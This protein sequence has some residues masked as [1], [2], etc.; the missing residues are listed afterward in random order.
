MGI[1]LQGSRKKAVLMTKVCTH[2]RDKNVAMRMLEKSLRR[3]R[4]DYL[5]ICQIHEVVYWSDPDL[6]FAPN[7][8]AEVLVQAKQEGK[9]RFVG[10]TGHEDLSHDFAFDTVQLQLNCF[11]A[12]FR[13]FE[14]SILPELIRRG[15]APLGM[16]SMG[17][18]GEMVKQGAV[19]ADEAPRY[20]NEPA[21]RYHY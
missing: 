16:K 3:L 13:S 11:E 20:A 8:A 10:F 7:G 14:A 21:G 12:T 5:D 6:I 4:T 17:G 2:G 19:T 1:A 18:S 15:I 9:V